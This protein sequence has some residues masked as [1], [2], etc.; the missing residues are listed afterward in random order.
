MGLGKIPGGSSRAMRLDPFSLP[1]RFAAEDA[2]ADEAI[3]HVELHRER[4]ILRRAVRGMRYKLNLPLT[5][6]LGL[7]VRQPHSSSCGETAIVLQHRDPALSVP[8]FVASD[9]DDLTAI[10][11]TWARVLRLPLLSAGHQQ[12]AAHPQALKL[13]AVIPR[14]RRGALRA[15]RPSILSRRKPGKMSKAPTIHREDEI[16][17]RD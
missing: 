12:G 11:E 4:V 13:G 16:I 17:A 3:R 5:T 6:Y 8:L 9:E 10:S 1:L 2:A 15:R 7:L 14:R